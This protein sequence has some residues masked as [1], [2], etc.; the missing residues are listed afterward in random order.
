MSIT[1]DTIVYN[2]PFKTINRRAEILFK[3]SAGRTANGVLHAEPI[4][5]YYNYDLEVGMS[6]KN[7]TDYAALWLKLTE[8]TANHTITLPDESNTLTFNCYFAN[9]R[10]TVQRWNEGGTNYFKNL[11]FSVIPTSPARVPA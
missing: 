10:D 1:I 6:R 7:A 11:S 5:T 3:D 9:I 2:L 8:P 4:G